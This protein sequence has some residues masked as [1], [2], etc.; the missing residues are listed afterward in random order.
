MKYAELKKHISEKKFDSAYFFSG[1]DEF[2]KSWAIKMFKAA[3]PNPDMNFIALDGTD[4][5]AALDA[6]MSYPIMGSL[7]IVRLDVFPSDFARLAAYFDNPTESSVLLVSE[8]SEPRSAKKKQELEKLKGRFTEIDCSP[9]DR[10]TLAL[11]IANEAQKYGASVSESAAEL[12]IEYSRSDMSRISGETAKLAAYKS[13]GTIEAEDV[14]EFVSQ[15]EEYKIWELSSAIAARNAAE[16]MRI[17][18]K[19]EEDKT[20]FVAMF[21]AVY[22]HFHNLFYIAVSAEDD[23]IDALGLTTAN[24]SRLKSGAA[25]FGT[26]NLKNIL[27]YLAELDASSK[28]GKLDKTVA[29]R[30]MIA[31]L[32][33]AL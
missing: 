7:R 4:E 20:E 24:Y 13:G 17:A 31:G 3:T 33:G 16:A 1:S 5:D 22:K 25:K 2:L 8:F 29:A 23:A 10:R 28:S 15:S 12:L 6:L 14:R 9:L 19:F 27:L 11:W 18:E 26:R 21:G 30:T 32:I